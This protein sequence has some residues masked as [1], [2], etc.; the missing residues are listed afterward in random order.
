MFD[1]VKELAAFAAV[2]TPLLIELRDGREVTLENFKV[3]IDGKTYEL[4]GKVKLA[5]K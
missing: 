5:P 3:T 4:N 2:A 1:N